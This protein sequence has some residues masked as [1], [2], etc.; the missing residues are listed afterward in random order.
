MIVMLVGKENIITA[1]M[2]TLPMKRF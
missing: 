1:M 2:L